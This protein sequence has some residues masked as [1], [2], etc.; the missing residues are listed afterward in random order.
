MNDR[1]VNAFKE[2][3][4]ELL[5]ELEAVLLELEKNSEDAELLARA[6]RALHTIKGSSGMFGFDDIAMF[7]HDIENIFDQLRNGEIKINKELINL[8]LAAKDQIQG[9]LENK[10]GNSIDDEKTRQLLTAFR[11]LVSAKDQAKP[12][13][14]KEREF[15][16]ETES[17]KSVY[18]IKFAPNIGMLRNGSNPIALLNELRSMGKAAIRGEFKSLPDLSDLDPQGCYAEWI[19]ILQTSSSVDAIKDVFIFVEDECRLKVET[20]EKQTSKE[21]DD[22]ILQKITAALDSKKDFTKSDLQRILSLDYGQENSKEAYKVKTDRPGDKQQKADNSSSLRVAAEKLDELVNLV[23]ELVTVQA[24]LTE[25]AVQK[26]DADVQGIAEEIERI[27]WALRDSA[28]N[29]RMLPIGTTFNKFNRLTRDLSHELGK[30]IELVTMGAETE[31]DKNVIEK[32]SDP[33]VHIIR[34]CIDHGIEK[35]DVRKAAGKPEKGTVK[36]SASHSGAFV[37]I[38]I[39][40][41]GAG[42]DKEKL[43]QKAKM[44][45]LIAED[46]VLS[47][48]EMLNLV[49]SPGLSTAKEVTSVSGRGVGMDVVKRAIESL[50]GNIDVK[51]TLGSGSTFTLK[52]PLTLAIIEG[53]LVK[54]AKD[55]YIIPLSIVEECI[56]LTAEEINRGKGKAL[57]NVRNELVPYVA[58]RREFVITGDA[59]A[60]QQAVIVNEDGFRIGFVVDEVIGEHQTVI[61]S[62]GKLYRNAE[63]ISGAT[64]LGDGTVALIIDANKLIKM[65]EKIE[66]NLIEA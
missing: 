34:N 50:R 49:F 6:F 3:A 62:L 26:N 1:H 28:L 7:T 11:G 58:L 63:H 2:E 23:G 21:F 59:P 12:A 32:L 17:V 54:I 27:T 55:F 10:T 57:A 29:I 44:N 42:I 45:G 60:I 18:K 41:D 43:L 52:I 61:K 19:I 47:E 8:T 53:L 4:A 48:K 33:L 13:V 9:M 37:V 56:E 14:K 40:D 31:L 66:D 65:A 30:N 24:H 51:T 22:E 46:A 38:E 35:A 16:P 25:I 15:Q 64:I 39:S 5:A 20:L 36:L